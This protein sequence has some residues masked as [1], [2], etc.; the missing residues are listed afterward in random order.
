MDRKDDHFKA[1]YFTKNVHFKLKCVF[2]NFHLY[3]ETVRVL[4]C[5]LYG[6]PLITYDK[7]DNADGILVK[8]HGDNTERF[9]TTSNLALIST[10]T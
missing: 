7:I 10:S 9:R 1:K 2:L 3:S 5:C 8:H 6:A 4:L